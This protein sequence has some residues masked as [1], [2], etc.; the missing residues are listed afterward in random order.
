VADRENAR[1]RAAYEEANKPVREGDAKAVLRWE[2]GLALSHPHR[3]AGGGLA[4]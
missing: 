4:I 3:E 2:G 1:R